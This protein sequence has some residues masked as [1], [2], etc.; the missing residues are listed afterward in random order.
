MKNVRRTS[1]RRRDIA[2][3]TAGAAVHPQQLVVA[4]KVAECDGRVDAQPHC[5]NA[6]PRNR[7]LPATRFLS[8][9]S[10]SSSRANV[11]NEK[12]SN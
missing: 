3:V 2:L 10:L 12:V 6:T 1:R 8:M 9:P 11:G 4:H 7:F 5:T